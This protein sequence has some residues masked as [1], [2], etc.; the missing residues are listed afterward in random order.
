MRRITQYILTFIILM[1]GAGGYT[2]LNFKPTTTDANIGS[3][4]SQVD[5]IF[6]ETLNKIMYA[7]TASADFA[8]IV[9]TTQEMFYISGDFSLNNTE[10]LTFEFNMNIQKNNGKI[11]L[12]SESEDNVLLSGDNVLLSENNNLLSTKYDLQNNFVNISQINLVYVDNFAF[13][14]IGNV[15]FK[16]AFDDKTSFENIITKITPLLNQYIPLDLNN[17]DLTNVMSML[18]IESKEIENGY[19]I[20]IGVMDMV[21]VE[22]EA[23]KNY[24]PTKIDIIGNIQDVKIEA[25]INVDFES[26]TPEINEPVDADSIPN[27]SNSTHLLPLLL[28]FIDSSTFEINFDVTSSGSQTLSGS[29]L[30]DLTL[31]VA[32]INLSCNDVDAVLIFKN[33]NVY[34]NIE[35]IGIYANLKN[36]NEI[37]D[38]L[39]QIFNKDIT[40]SFNNFFN[41]LLNNNKTNDNLEELPNSSQ[42]NNNQYLNGNYS[43]L[44]NQL[45]NVLSGIEIVDD[46][47]ELYFGD[48]YVLLKVN[49][50]N[51]LEEIVVKYK[52]LIINSSINTVESVFVETPKNNVEL[53]K[54]L[55]KVNR[56]AEILNGA[57]E[58]RIE[59]QYGNE[60][61][62]ADVNVESL[63]PLKMS[64]KTEVFGLP[65]NIIVIEKE[66]YFGYADIKI[67]SNIDEI[68]S[69]IKEN[70]VLSLFQPIINQLQEQLG[71]R[72]IGINEIKDKITQFQNLAKE[73]IDISKIQTILETITTKLGYESIRECLIDVI[74]NLNIT[75]N[76]IELNIQDIS[77]QL[78]QEQNENFE[79]VIS[80]TNK[81]ISITTS[82]TTTQIAPL[83]NAVELTEIL[84]KVNRVAEIL[85]GA[86]ETRIE[87]Q[88][89][90]ETYFADVN[91][92]SLKPLKMSVKTEVFGLP[93]NI[94]VIEKEIYFGYADIKIKSNIDEIMSLIKENNVLSLFQP[95]IN[96][97]QEQLGLRDIGINEIK[98]KITQFQNLA[99]ETIDISKIQTI[100]ETITTKLGYESIRECLIDVI[101]NLN[102]TENSIEL[103]IQDISLQLKQEQNENFEIVISQTNKKISITT[104]QTTT[105]IAPLENAVELT[106]IINNFSNLFNNIK[107]FQFAFDVNLDINQKE[108]TMTI[109]MDIKNSAYK[110]ETLIDNTPV[111]IYYINEKIYLSIDNKIN[112]NIN[113]KDTE[114]I[115]NLI[116]Q[117]ID[118]DV[119]YIYTIINNLLPYIDDLYSQINNCLNNLKTTFVETLKNLD[120]SSMQKIDSKK[121][122]E[123]LKILKTSILQTIN[124][125]AYQLSF[126]INNFVNSI[127]TITGNKFDELIINWLNNLNGVVGQNNINNIINLVNNGNIEFVLNLNKN[128]WLDSLIVKLYNCNDYINLNFDFCDFKEVVLPNIEFIDVAGLLDLGYY[129]NEFLINKTLT[130]NF[131]LNISNQ[132]F[133]IDF[134]L[135]VSK[136]Q[137]VAQ[138]SSH[139]LGLDIYINIIGTN[140]YVSADE[141]KLSLNVNEIPDLLNKLNSLLKLNLDL[142]KIDDIVEILNNVL[143]LNFKEIFNEFNNTNL[144]NKD[145]QDVLNKINRIAV[146]NNVL[147]INIL[148]DFNIELNLLEQF[149]GSGVISFN[150]DNSTKQTDV[151]NAND[152]KTM[153]S[154]QNKL[155]LE[156][157]FKSLNPNFVNINVADYQ[158]YV[159]VYNFLY[160][161]IDKYNI[162]KN[163]G[164]DIVVKV[165][166]KYFDA[167]IA[168]DLTNLQ[169]FTMSLK[170]V[171]QENKIDKNGKETVQNYNIELLL[172]NQQIYIKVNDKY[173]TIK[174]SSIEEIIQ[175]V[176]IFVDVDLSEILKMININTGELNMDEIQNMLPEYGSQNVFKLDLI[177]NIKLNS[178]TLTII[179][180][181]NQ[182][183]IFTNGESSL[184]SLI[185]KNVKFANF[186]ISINSDFTK[187]YTPVQKAN[188]SYLDISELGSLALE[189]K[190]TIE[191]REEIKFKGT[192]GLSIIGLD[193]AFS[194][195]V[196]LLI[197]KNLI[198]NQVG[199]SVNLTNL[200]D[201]TVLINFVSPDSSKPT[202]WGV[203]NHKTYIDIFDGKIF[204][205]RVADLKIGKWYN[206]FNPT[207]VYGAIQN[208]GFALLSDVSKSVE[209]ILKTVQYAIGWK[210]SIHDIII[211]QINKA[212]PPTNCT[213]EKWLKNFVYSNNGYAKSYNVLLDGAYVTENVNV[214][215][216]NLTIYSNTNEI[217]G[218]YAELGLLNN[219]SISVQTSGSGLKLVENLTYYI[220][221]MNRLNNLKFNCAE[222]G[223]YNQLVV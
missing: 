90:N 170:T 34:L 179:L 102:I 113:L 203:S 21:F 157:D 168:I 144:T 20:D 205:K 1:A 118:F 47:F 218:V 202:I 6:N 194:V 151:Y 207:Q 201:S 92:E 69:L 19:S 163:F 115:L 214:N 83:E 188:V 125:N 132:E 190:T 146:E 119:Q 131:V 185:V 169:N 73:T 196:E 116:N 91:V 195:D 162:T 43:S 108:F 77:L 127:S 191:N 147:K 46:G 58:T 182:E 2:I 123:I 219:N 51:K 41:N 55:T 193:N 172:E 89:G 180:N 210:D 29:F 104:S 75:E 24:M 140:I 80:Q 64:V 192:I 7:T 112:L 8:L 14:T 175:A 221:M 45:L 138:F 213:Y 99:K 71:L 106:E 27:I 135:D 212:E 114:E 220:D 15:K 87:V 23:N 198:N 178:N 96:Q 129:V 59:V 66:I 16:L 111:Y 183:I 160:N 222:S 107:N 204:I 48:V 161:I 130:G 124:L 57:I 186:D 65:L 52:N 139:I 145:L 63:K 68:M 39:S 38:L 121:I 109:T 35:N 197:V 4:T 209:S 85:N 120:I 173:L 174:L 3:T 137:L 95:I 177:K 158:N 12:Q 148:N 105:Q 84:A 142:S 94:I 200:P 31:N 10:N 62:F 36:F 165:G 159:N 184:S 70:N 153:S 33:N 30:I 49:Q 18:D 26:L 133:I 32:K 141:F 217:T 37:L 215:D 56:V 53:T 167:E 189:T 128:S 101:K 136:S 93:L 61:Y 223:Y 82:Q 98:D 155:V 9:E 42:N 22:I 100:L 88:Y 216:I 181:G 126:S 164:A 67:K 74:K 86:I 208:Q 110:I 154:I 166:E 60:T 206:G 150:I 28:Q 143:T 149:L 97:L 50:V 11:D 54:I 117:Y 199:I 44:I 187:I 79:I 17:M 156:F 152:N 5:P 134:G 211:N 81:K 103:N 72:D 176:K 25:D 40:S 122:E 76:S 171:L 13:I 78:K